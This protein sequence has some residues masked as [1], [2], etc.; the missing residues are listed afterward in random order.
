MKTLRTYLATVAIVIPLVYGCASAPTQ[1]TQNTDITT[2]ASSI[3]SLL[4]PYVAELK[5]KAEQ[6]DAN[7]QNN[8]G[9]MYAY[10]NGVPKDLKEAVRLYRRAAEQGLV[11][12][13]YN[14]VN[15]YDTGR[16]VPKNDVGEVD[17]RR[18]DEQGLANVQYNLGLMYF[19]GRGVPKNDVEA[20]KWYRKAAEQ[21]YAAAQLELGGIYSHGGLDVP[22]NAVEAVKWYRRGAEQG[23]D[24]AQFRLGEM[25]YYGRGVRQ[26]YVEAY[27]LFSIAIAATNGRYVEDRRR[28]ELEMT[29]AQI[30]EAQRMSANWVPGQPIKIP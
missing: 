24:Y 15:T 26:N 17:F 22:E 13:Q 30:G 18:A 7:A 11:I 10:G 28:L 21:G 20:V 16:V 25:Y 23:D 19:A 8:L 5:S 6:G 29:P 1:H 3:P 12:A 27:A 9:I 4:D 14:L 2:S